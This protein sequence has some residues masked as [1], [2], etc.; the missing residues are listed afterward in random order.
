MRV[1]FWQELLHGV[2]IDRLYEKWGLDFM[3]S[4][5]CQAPQMMIHTIQSMINFDWIPN[6]LKPI[7]CG[8]FIPIIILM[9][10]NY[11]VVVGI[12]GNDN[13]LKGSM[14]LT[15]FVYLLAALRGSSV[16]NKPEMK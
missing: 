15:A 5:T 9:F 11:N 8:M 12:A 10:F 1:F 7:F 6:R 2:V 4:L 13:L 14:Y 3:R 16:L